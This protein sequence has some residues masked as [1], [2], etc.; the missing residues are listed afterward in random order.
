MPTTNIYSVNKKKNLDAF[1]R[2]TAPYNLQ[3]KLNFIMIFLETVN[4]Q[5]DE[6]HFIHCKPAETQTETVWWHN[7]WMI[8]TWDEIY[9]SDWS[10]VMSV[11]SKRLRYS[12]ATIL[13]KSL[14]WT[15]TEHTHYIITEIKKRPSWPR[16][17]SGIWITFDKS[18]CL[19]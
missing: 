18:L 5:P 9:L 17:V 7:S 8:N 1:N 14:L 12:S 6:P 16:T 11:N 10:N 3:I 13:L 19:L 4:I 15:Q 2:L